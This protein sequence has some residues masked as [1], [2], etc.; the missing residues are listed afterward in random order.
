[1]F[2]A[3]CNCKKAT[4]FGFNFLV[5]RSTT[6]LTNALSLGKD[7]TVNC[8]SSRPGNPD[9]A[10]YGT[11]NSSAALATAENS[12]ALTPPT[13]RIETLS[14]MTSLLAPAVAS[15]TEARLSYLTT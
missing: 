1:M 10:T 12:V 6:P 13:H 14:S 2:T 9:K 3:S 15:A 5:N 7:D 8:F 4:V 11:L